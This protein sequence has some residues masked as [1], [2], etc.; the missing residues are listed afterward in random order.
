ML[1]TMM[2][3]SPMTSV[4]LKEAK[5]FSRELSVIQAS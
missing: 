2:E 4:Y 5:A 3:R 1:A